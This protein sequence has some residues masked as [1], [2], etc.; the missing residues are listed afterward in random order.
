MYFSLFKY[1]PLILVMFGL[2]SIW[3][4]RMAY[5]Q[6]SYAGAQIGALF[7]IF[8]FGLL[9]VGPVLGIA[10]LIMLNRNRK[11]FSASFNKDNNRHL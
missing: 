9:F 1:G 10:S 11:L 6:K 4:A 8:G 3:G 2:I 5:G 7:S